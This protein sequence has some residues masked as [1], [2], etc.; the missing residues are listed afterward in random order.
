MAHIAGRIAEAIEAE[1]LTE[2]TGHPADEAYNQA[3]DD[4]LSAVEAVAAEPDPLRELAEWLVG[5]YR[6]MSTKVAVEALDEAIARARRALGRT[7]ED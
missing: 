5:R 3:I 7:K 4:A 2:G 6:P 1:R